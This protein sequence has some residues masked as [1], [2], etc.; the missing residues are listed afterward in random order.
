MCSVKM[1]FKLIVFLFALIAHQSLVNGSEDQTDNLSNLELPNSCLR[2]S[3][4]IK[5][6]KVSEDV[7]PVFCDA[8]LAGPGWIV[9]QRRKDARE[10]FNRSWDDYRQGFGQL[11]GSFFIGLD[12]L[13]QLT[14]SRSHELYIYLR[15]NAN[16]TRFARYSNFVIGD[17]SEQFRLKS[18]G[19]FQGTAGNSLEY[20]LGM[21]FSTYDEDND[22]HEINCAAEWESGWWF[23]D[24]YQR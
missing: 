8:D 7:F 15:N 1:E 2:H 22:K 21:K 17:S 23:G 3:S 12:K 19:K 4:G 20:H 5:T 14:T 24:C 18:L 10:S 11:N 9:I 16:E 6:I 13:H